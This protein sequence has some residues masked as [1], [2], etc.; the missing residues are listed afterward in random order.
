MSLLA[1]MQKPCMHAKAKSSKNFRVIDRLFFVQNNW[2][3]KLALGHAGC[4]QS[5]GHIPSTSF[6]HS[7]ETSP[8]P[9]NS[10]TSSLVPRPLC[11]QPLNVLN[12]PRLPHTSDMTDV[13]EIC[14]ISSFVRPR[15]RLS[16]NRC[17][18]PVASS[19][20]N[21]RKGRFGLEAGSH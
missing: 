15:K 14:Q 7:D 20:L 4:Y 21:N 3:I 12:P 10:L 11:S 9:L 13:F 17:S 19:Q 18:S 16:K 8:R 1:T 6:I 2:K 5:A